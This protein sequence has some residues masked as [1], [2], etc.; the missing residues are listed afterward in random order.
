[1]CDPLAVA[2]E[3]AS[4]IQPKL[5]VGRYLGHHA[6]TGSVLIMTIV[7]LVTGAGFRRTGKE[8]RWN[9]S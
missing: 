4:G 3:V 8:D 1:M 6:G 2:R 5:Y 7:G 9:V